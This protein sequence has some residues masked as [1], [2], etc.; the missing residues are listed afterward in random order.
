MGNKF[1]RNQKTIFDVGHNIDAINKSI[2]E[3]N[4]LTYENL[5]M[6]IGFV[7][8]KN[9]NK[10]LNLLPKNANYYFCKPNISRG[11]AK[12]NVF[13]KISQKFNL[14]GNCYIYLSLCLKSK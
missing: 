2:N 6:V 11:F 8:D 14:T 13:S 3:I 5:H 7:K 4:E 9:L 12:E 10:I 1:L